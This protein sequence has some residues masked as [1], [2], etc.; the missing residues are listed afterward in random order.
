MSNLLP[1]ECEARC[2]IVKHKLNPKK[3]RSKKVRSGVKWIAALTV[4]SFV[5]DMPPLLIVLNYHLVKISD[6]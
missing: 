6:K 1:P 5:N 2:K 3:L 4:A